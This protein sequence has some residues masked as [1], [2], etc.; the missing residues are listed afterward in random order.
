M[1]GGCFPR[2]FS[3][4]FEPELEALLEGFRRLVIESSWSLKESTG[5]VDFFRLFSSS[6]RAS[7]SSAPLALSPQNNPAACLANWCDFFP[8]SGVVFAAPERGGLDFVGV[9]DEPGTFWQVGMAVTRSTKDAGQLAEQLGG[10][11]RDSPSNNPLWEPH[12]LGT[13]WFGRKTWFVAMLSISCW[14]EQVTCRMVLKRAPACSWD[15]CS[16]ARSTSWVWMFCRASSVYCLATAKAGARRW[17]A[18]GKTR[19]SWGSCSL[20]M[21]S[22]MESRA[23]FLACQ[24]SA[25]S[26]AWSLVLF[27]VAAIA[28]LMESS[29]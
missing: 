22:R 28:G 1:A 16:L 3:Q 18:R 11:R 21:S 12:R 15:T 24:A 27:S 6:L 13:I 7:A 2:T 20:G 19:V 9:L 23:S 14:K 17:V 4:S 8:E 25:S 10:P 5:P 26:L 29:Q